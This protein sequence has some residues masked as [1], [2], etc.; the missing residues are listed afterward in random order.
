[1][2]GQFLIQA[3]DVREESR[4]GLIWG[5][6]AAQVLSGAGAGGPQRCRGE[7]ALPVSLTLRLFQR[8]SRAPACSRPAGDFSEAE[9][10][11]LPADSPAPSGGLSRADDAGALPG[12]LVPSAAAL[13]TRTSGFWLPALRRQLES[14]KS[15]IC[16]WEGQSCFC[17]NS[18]SLG[19]LEC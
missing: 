19:A 11:S 14:A 8:A 2:W 3:E 7:T 4:H 1:M 15:L 9:G 12:R 17:Q 16:F 13:D 10:L 6:R 5:H 18:Q